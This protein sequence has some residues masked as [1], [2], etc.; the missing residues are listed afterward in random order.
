M[1]VEERV[2]NS[3]ESRSRAMCSPDYHF[4][5][6]KGLQTNEEYCTERRILL[7]YIF[8]RSNKTN[9]NSQCSSLT[10]ITASILQF[11][12]PSLQISFLHLSPKV[13][14]IWS[15]GRRFLKFQ[16]LDTLPLHKKSPKQGQTRHNHADLEYRVQ[17]IVKS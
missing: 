7:S 1:G 2:L 8:L 4:C 6:R 5:L 3:I 9:T 12:I 17:R 10:K 16:S 14:R 13:C 11:P 15:T